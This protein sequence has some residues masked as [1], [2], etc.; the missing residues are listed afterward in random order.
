MIR[1]IGL[2]ILLATV[3]LTVSWFADRPGTVAIVWQEWRVDTSV[4]VLLAVVA[5]IAAA[6]AFLYRFWRGI[7]GAPRAFG[8]WRRER[9]RRKGYVA[10]TQGMVA[11]AA[12]DPDEAR[13]QARR[14]DV[15][16]NEPPLTM[17]LS[18]QAAQLNGDEE[19][20][21]RYFTQMLERPE[22]EFLGLRGL[23][24][25]A[26]RSGDDARAIELARRARR[27]RPKTLWVLRTLFELEARVG[28]WRA[29]AETL[30]LAQR[31]GALPAAEA[32]RHE[33]AVLIEL[34]RAAAAAGDGRDALRLA[35]QAYRADPDHPAAALWLVRCSIDTGKTRAA[36]R[37][38]EEQWARTPHPD[39]LAAYRQARPVA[40]PL[41]WV[42]QVERLARLAPLHRESMLALAQANLEARL[43]GEAR[44]HL[45]AALDAANGQPDSGICRL[46]AQLEDD[47]SGDQAAVRRWL[48][49][50]AEAP[51]EPA[52]VCDACGAVYE[53]WQARCARCHS[54]N[55]L[56]WRQPARVMP[57]LVESAGRGDKTETDA[58][59][60]TS[61]T[62][63]GS[64]D[65]TDSRDVN[66]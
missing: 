20:A 9:R 1:A 65:T 47:E 7:V 60:A 49:R 58:L 10:L 5:L 55:R 32:R 18:A 62:A 37:V 17:L 16:L 33:A 25:Q 53:Q 52:W 11:V 15:L 28:E 56:A 63:A 29:A 48:A 54:F 3:M 61:P 4:P 6:A 46:M 19:A 13:R 50:A 40:E 34:S 31:A 36:E 44:R 51:P 57:K 14:A 59:P 39:L 42:K 66:A 12:G 26:M 8:R 64:A 23:L 2:L 38:I 30:A 45:T 21:S 24:I 43:W 22:T 27:L 41:Q 35:Q